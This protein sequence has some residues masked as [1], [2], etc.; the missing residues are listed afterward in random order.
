MPPRIRSDSSLSDASNMHGIATGI[1]PA[2]SATLPAVR[3]FFSPSTMSKKKMVLLI[4]LAL[5]CFAVALFAT[6]YACHRGFRRTV[7][8]WRGAVPWIVQYHCLKFHSDYIAKHSEKQWE[9]IEQDFHFTAA[10]KVVEIVQEMGGIYVKIGQA[11]STMGQ[12]LLPE[13]YV[14]AMRP[15]QNGIRPRDY[16]TIS[17]IIEASTGRKMKDIFEEFEQEPIG[18]ATIGQAHRA[19]LKQQSQLSSRGHNQQVVVKVQYPEVADLFDA[20]LNNLEWLR[21]ILLPERSA[22]LLANIRKRHEREMDFR[23]E[24]Q[25]LIEC[26]KNM[27]KHGLEPKY[28]RIP[29]VLNE[30]GLCTE[31]VLV[32]EYLEGVSLKDV[33]EEEQDRIAR[34]LGKKD[35]EELRFT[36]AKRMKEHFEQGGGGEQEGE[37]QMKLMGAGSN[38]QARL[39]NVLGPFAIHGLRHYARLRDQVVQLTAGL[40]RSGTSSNQK[41]SRSRH[42]NLGKVLKTVIHVHAVQVLI[43]GTY[44]QDPHPGNIVV[45]DDGRVGLLDY[46]MVG[47]LSD[48]QRLNVADT[49]FNLAHNNPQKVAKLYLD[50]GYHITF[51]GDKVVDPQVLFRISSTHFNK[52]DLTPVPISEDSSFNHDGK[53]IGVVELFEKMDVIFIPDWVVQAR[54]VGRLL[55]GV[56]A[57]AARPVS[58]AKEWEPVAKRA[59]KQRKKERKY[60]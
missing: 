30:T 59:L 12:G 52:I 60:R 57:Q 6:L 43:D 47:R 58:L 24:A 21:R 54:R 13:E 28:V 41:Q 17:K 35:G 32:M 4:F 33:M 46:G 55:M 22:A 42:I 16:K 19:I 56:S 20:D 3:S 9:K 23:L 48:E 36:I 49:I 11:M 51:K 40:R 53:E 37:T 29:R 50:D 10:P 8:F 27:Q 31:N 45:L 7:H 44:N 25:H 18:A 34:A 5:L 14:Q 15:L 38:R 2:V 39:W 26:S 1:S